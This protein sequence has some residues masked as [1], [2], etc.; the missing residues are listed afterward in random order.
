MKQLFPALLM[1]LA[2]LPVA[3]QE[4]M[5]RT[6]C[7]E[8]YQR[9]ADLVSPNDANVGLQVQLLRVTPDG[10]CQFRGGDPGFDD[11]PFSTFE[12]RMENSARWTRD[13]IPPLAIDVRIDDFDPEDARSSRPFGAP[14]L[15]VAATLRQD[16]DEGIVI[17]ER[18]VISNDFGDILIVS[19]VFERVFLSSPSMMQVSMGSATFKAGLVSMTLDGTHENP[20]GFHGNI[21]VSG[22]PRTQSEAAFDGISSLPDGLMDDASRA[23]LMAY[24]ADLPGPVGT[25]EVSV[26]SERGLGLMQIGSAVYSGFTSVVDGGAISNEMEIM[27]DGLS[28]TANWSPTAQ[29]AD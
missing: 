7:Q 6:S 11:V 2:A 10:W 29:M 28:V 12:W 20:F 27:F 24:A 22:T 18:V 21:E 26:A 23:E 8:T 25:L 9:A 14:P 5:T 4:R 3:A 15:D 17:L 16:P 13:G 19:G 1:V